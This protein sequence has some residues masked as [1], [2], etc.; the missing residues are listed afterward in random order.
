MPN[1]DWDKIKAEY[2]AG[3]I[4]QRNLAEKHGVTADQLMHRA[5]RERWAD[6]REAVSS[7]AA[8]KAQQK[9]VS[10]RAKDIAALDN[11]R[12][13]LISKLGK[14]V[15]KFPDVPGNRM[16]QTMTEIIPPKDDEDSESKPVKLPKKKTVRFESD[17]WKMAATLEKL[18]AMT[19]YSI[20]SGDDADDGFLEALN[21]ESAEVTED[22]SDIPDDL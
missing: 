8:A 9:I 19:G 5:N 3:G 15:E 16:E 20:G 21:A 17:L 11:I 13:S 4:S 18:M 6:Q 22:A 7:K 12:T 2:L 1:V 10:Q 14:A